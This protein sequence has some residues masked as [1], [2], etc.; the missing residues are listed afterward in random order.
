MMMITW[1][2]LMTMLTMVDEV[3]V[4]EAADEPQVD[5]EVNQLTHSHK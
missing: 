3:Q 5:I 1:P 2:L 4:E